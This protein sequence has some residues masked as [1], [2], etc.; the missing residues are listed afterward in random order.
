MPYQVSTAFNKFMNEFVNLDAEDTREGKK[1]RDWLVDEQL[2][3]FPDQDET[4]PLL[5]S[6][7]KMWFGS[8]SRR[9]KIREL[10]DID[11]MIIMHAQGS[12]YFESGGCVHLLPGQN[13]RFLDYLDDSKQWINSRK[14]VNKFVSSLKNVPQYSKADSKR[15]G[16]A[17]T[18]KL[19]TRKWNFDIVPAFCTAPAADGTNFYLIPDGDGNWKKTDP[20]IDKDRTTRLNQKHDGNILNAIRLVKYW[21]KKRGVPAIGSY[22]LETILLNRYDSLNEG[23]MSKWVDREFPLALRELASAVL[24]S[25][26]DQKSFQGNINNLSFENRWKVSDKATSD[27]E[28]AEEA[29]NL[30]FSDPVESGKI[31]QQILGNDFPT[32][33]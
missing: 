30:E 29:I 21:K 25:V 5:R 17:A 15:Q 18:L 1:S 6:T 11:M 31:W 20:R 3:K 12:T 8:F 7:P 24:G 4:F 19:L 13:S 14:I 27:A 26:D 9:T 28:L 2:N 10:D 22:L 16:E 33:E 23:G 32:E